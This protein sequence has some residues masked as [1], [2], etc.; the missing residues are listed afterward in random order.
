MSIEERT[1][2][3]VKHTVYN[4]KERKETNDWFPDEGT[5]ELNPEQ[6]KNLKVL[7][8]KPKEH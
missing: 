1:V 4:E 5:I 3:A 6:K 2:G 8:Q 7:F